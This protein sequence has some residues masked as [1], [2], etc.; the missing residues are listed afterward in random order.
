MAVSEDEHVACDGADAFDHPRGAS[1][2]LVECLATW[3]AI[4]EEDPPRPPLAN[5]V[6]RQSLVVAVVPLHEV[7]IDDRACIEAGKG[8]G[9]ARTLQRAH[10]HRGERPAG[11]D[12]GQAT[13][14]V[15]PSGIEWDVT[16][17]GVPFDP[18]PRGLAVTNDDD[19]LCGVVGAGIHGRPYPAVFDRLGP[20]STPA[21]TRRRDP[22]PPRPLS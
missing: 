21:R 6:A 3:R 20:A 11:K 17:A 18:A 10:E 5:L 13:R 22:D 1:G 4:A 7:G 16:P 8:T 19:T 15:S 14:L 2:N 12:R 9:L